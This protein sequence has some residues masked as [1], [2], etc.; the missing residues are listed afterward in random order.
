MKPIVSIIPIMTG[1]T[2]PSG[3]VIY[4]SSY[5]DRLAWY[6]FDGNDTQSATN[7]W[8]DWNNKLNNTP[9][10]C[11]VGYDFK[12]YVYV[13][14]ISVSFYGDTEYTAC[15]Q[16]RY[17]GEWITTI[18]SITILASPNYNKLDI[19]L[20]NKMICDAVR[21]CILSGDKPYFMMYNG[22]S[23]VCELIVNGFDI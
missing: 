17:K 1:Y 13:D 2:T 21:L 4:S 22:G 11:Y 6:A 19:Q 7:A 18:S 20:S 5:G 10:K 16:C 8:T 23:N 14:N 12:K 3:K 9:N 15:F